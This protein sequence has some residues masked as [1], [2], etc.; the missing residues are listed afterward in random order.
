MTDQ[1]N[2]GADE[3]VAPALDI[4]LKRQSAVSWFDLR[5]LLA[6]A[7][8]TVAATI[9]GSMSGRREL[10]A[11]LDPCGENCVMDYPD[12]SDRDEM[13]IDYM[14]DT[15]DGW[16]ATM[17]VAWLLGR[18]ALIL[19]KDG[20][21]TEQVIPGNQDEYPVKAAGDEIRLEHGELLIAGGDQV[22]PTASPEEYENRFGNPLACA[23]FSQSPPRTILAIPGNHDWYDGL[24]SF[25]RLFCQSEGARRWFGAWQARQRRSY[26]TAKLPHGWWLWGVDTALGDD[27]DPPQYDYFRQAAGQLKPGERVILCIPGPHWLMADGNESPDALEERQLQNKLRIIVELAKRG[28]RNEVPL[29]LTG[30]LHYYAHFRSG[31]PDKHDIGDRQHYLICGG[32]GAFGLGTLDVPKQI[33]VEKEGAH[34]DEDALFPSREDSCRLRRRVWKFPFQNPGFC[35]V[36]ATIQLVALW[37]LHS[38]RSPLHDVGSTLADG[39]T[40]KGWVTY[41][42]S[43]P[44]STDGLLMALESVGLALFYPALLVGTAVVVTGFVAFALSG[45]RRKGDTFAAGLAGLVHVVLQILGSVVI[46]WAIAHGLHSVLADRMMEP[47]EPW[48]AV[49][50]SAPALF[51]W[52]GFLFGGYLYFG[53]ILTGVHD[54]EVFSAQGIE[55]YKSFLRMKITAEDLVIY[56]IGLK[57]VARRWYAAPDINEAGK[58]HPNRDKYLAWKARLQTPEGC[59]RVVDPADPLAPHLIGDVIRLKGVGHREANVP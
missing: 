44:W 22:Y 12:F 17:S 30:D 42:M 27:L 3:Y 38:V 4:R 1:E 34:V 15:G 53:N 11:A 14:A 18:D 36:L 5:Q 59:V 10:M 13:W 40:G 21:P 52:C 58:A 20:S 31:D 55:D 32:G 49:L 28:G 2:S 35:A 57:K 33:I 39:F 43:T 46:V 48:I 41:Y 24:T 47:L 19:K 56:S 51:L 23:R 7:G 29:I 26:F 54:Q 25:V 50:V 8:K 9:V 16:N 45:K 37:L 6:T